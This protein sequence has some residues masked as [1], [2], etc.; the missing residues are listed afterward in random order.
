MK[1]RKL[2]AK[3]IYLIAS[4]DLRPAANQTC[5]PVQAAAEALLAKKLKA[6]GWTVVRGHPV[7]RAAKHGFIDSQKAGME[8]F[9]KL[10]PDAPLIVLETVWQ[11]SHHVLAGL[12]THRG[13]ILTVANWSGTYP[14]LVGML[15]LNGSMTKAGIAYSTLWSEN[16]SD[17]FFRA[18]LR[19][20][21][22]KGAVKHDE[23][24]V[25]D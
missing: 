3:H 12:L 16:F 24:H 23:S 19:Q 11:Y 6:E 10:D 13:P 22:K 25:R 2:P 21:L 4:G 8:V 17:D 1:P 20:W 9:R 14:G 5:W 18:G 7:D 15:N